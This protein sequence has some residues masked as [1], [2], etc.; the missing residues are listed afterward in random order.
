MCQQHEA[1]L[2]SLRAPQQQCSQAAE[3]SGPGPDLSHGQEAEFAAE[4]VAGARA[5]IAGK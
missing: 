2:T 1:G 3:E 5:V 4:E